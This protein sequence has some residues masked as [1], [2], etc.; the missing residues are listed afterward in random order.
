MTDAT[1]GI[2]DLTCYLRKVEDLRLPGAAHNGTGGPR[3]CPKLLHIERGAARLRTI[4]RPAD[5]SK[6]G[7]VASRTTHKSKV[8]T[9]AARQASYKAEVLAKYTGWRASNRLMTT[10]AFAG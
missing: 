4:M 2:R 8:K 3:Q 7:P 1:F 5:R 9:I 10:V 6:S